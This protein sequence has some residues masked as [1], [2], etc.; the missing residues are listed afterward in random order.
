MFGIMLGSGRRWVPGPRLQED[1]PLRP[2]PSEH[3]FPTVSVHP[4]PCR[5]CLPPP[6]PWTFNSFTAQ[7]AQLPHSWGPGAHSATA[8]GEGPGTWPGCMEMG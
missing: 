8:P 5:F 1:N 2:S 3:T 6:G 4:P 7:E